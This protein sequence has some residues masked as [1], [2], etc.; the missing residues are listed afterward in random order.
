V[1]G[2]ALRLKHEAVDR[3]PDQESA[4]DGGHCQSRQHNIHNKII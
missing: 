4:G 3:G 1:L 2:G